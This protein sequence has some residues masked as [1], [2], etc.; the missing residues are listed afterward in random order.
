M[1]SSRLAVLARPQGGTIQKPRTEYFPILPNPRNCNNLFIIWLSSHV[2]ETQGKRRR[3]V[4]K[5]V[6]GKKKPRKKSSPAG[7][8]PRAASRHLYRSA[9]T[10]RTPVKGF[11]EVL[12]STL[13]RP[14][15]FQ[16][17]AKAECGYCTTTRAIRA[18]IVPP[19]DQSDCNMT[20]SH[21]IM[22]VIIRYNT[23]ILSSYNWLLWLTSILRQLV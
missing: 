11:F 17:V 2:K 4:P 12:L 13:I 23:L 20:S 8:E 19:I 5:K 6:K 21:I 1:G 15:I 22:S 18:H 16:C 9:I 14:C 3:R 10:A 7:F